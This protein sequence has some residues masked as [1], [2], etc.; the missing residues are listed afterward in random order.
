MISETDFILAQTNYSFYI[1]IYAIHPFI[2][3]DFEKWSI[4]GVNQWR[5]LNSVWVDIS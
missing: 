5:D 1:Y 4:Q 2:Q 3:S